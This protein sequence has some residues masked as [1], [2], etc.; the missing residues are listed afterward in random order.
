MKLI[1]IK[2]IGYSACVLA[3]IIWALLAW[4]NPYFDGMTQFSPVHSFMMIVLPACLFALGLLQSRVS[5]LIGAFLWSLPY[6]VVMLTTSG[7]Y[8]LIGAICIIY[9]ICLMLCRVRRM[10]YW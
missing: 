4:E 1:H 6:G 9:L 5:I 2:G 7:I 8:L 3:V 10:R